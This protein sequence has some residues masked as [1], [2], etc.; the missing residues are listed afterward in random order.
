MKQKLYDH[1]KEDGAKA[2]HA[3][4]RTGLCAGVGYMQA[5]LQLTCCHRVAALASTEGGASPLTCVNPE[6]RQ[7]HRKREIEHDIYHPRGQIIQEYRGKFESLTASSGAPLALPLQA[8]DP[9]LS[10]LAR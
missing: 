5:A 9:P 4:Q 1:I 7:H 2:G 10:P 8:D 6:A 3:V